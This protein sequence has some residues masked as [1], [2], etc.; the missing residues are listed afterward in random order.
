VFWSYDSCLAFWVVGCG[1]VNAA[2]D[3]LNRDQNCAFAP[4]SLN[5]ANPGK[6][7]SLNQTD[8][9]G[10]KLPRRPKAS[11]DAKRHGAAGPGLTWGQNSPLLA[12]GVF[13]HTLPSLRGTSANGWLV[14]FGFAGSA[15]ARRLS[16]RVFTIEPDPART[17]VPWSAAMFVSSS[18][19]VA[20]C[21]LLLKCSIAC[22]DNKWR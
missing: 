21:L 11:F 5:R 2:S 15:R 9:V 22:W 7:G 10:C 12:S 1:E 19:P 20:A 6:P 13:H 14:T 17:G 18:V 3:R 8:Q 4:D 16:D